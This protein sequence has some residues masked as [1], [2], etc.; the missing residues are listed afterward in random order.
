MRK[1]A[2]VSQNLRPRR[3]IGSSTEEAYYFKNNY[4]SVQLKC[5]DLQADIDDL[6]IQ[7]RRELK[8]LQRR[9]RKETLKAKDRFKTNQRGLYKEIMTAVHDVNKKA[10][11]DKE[12]LLKQLDM[13]KDVLKEGGL[14]DV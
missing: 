2:P 6:D 4:E 1:S 7:L 12:A 9:F 14:I 5:D 13:F 11:S 8:S 3:S 10:Q